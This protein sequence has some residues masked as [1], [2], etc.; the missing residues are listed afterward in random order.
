M[1]FDA[2]E[3]EIRSIVAAKAARDPEQI[4]PY[5]DFEEDLGLD[6]LDRLDVLA[7]VEDELGIWIS[8]DPRWRTNWESGFPRTRPPRCAPSTACSRS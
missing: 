2:I 7:E 1:R 4:G 6:S 3:R 8:E 5:E